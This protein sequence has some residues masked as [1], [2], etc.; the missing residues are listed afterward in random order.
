MIMSLFLLSI[1][2]SSHQIRDL[3]LDRDGIDELFDV[4]EV[5]FNR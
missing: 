2:Q 1:Q 4:E 3:E 5:Q